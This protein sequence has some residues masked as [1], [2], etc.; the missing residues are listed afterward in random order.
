MERALENKVAIVTGATSGIGRASAI[1]LAKAGAKVVVSGRREKEGEE[2]VRLLQNAGGK[3]IFV[4]TDISKEDEV[5]ALVRTT[6]DTYGRLDIAFNRI[7]CVI[8]Y[9]SPNYRN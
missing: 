5:A 1:A 8:V 3:G 9:H 2:T 4:K 7:L 6:V